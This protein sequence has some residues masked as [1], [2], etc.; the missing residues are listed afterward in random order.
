MWERGRRKV[1]L[2]VRL[3]RVLFLSFVSGHSLLLSLV[4]VQIHVVIGL[5]SLPY[6]FV[7]ISCN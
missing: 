5:S 3:S 6:F 7:S 4:R 1:G 2:V